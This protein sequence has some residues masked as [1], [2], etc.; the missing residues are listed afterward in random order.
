MHKKIVSLIFIGGLLF[1]PF[2]HPMKDEQKNQETSTW[3][4]TKKCLKE[5][6]VVGLLGGITGSVAGALVNYKYSLGSMQLISRRGM[7]I[8]AGIGALSGAAT[9]INQKY[10]M[11][12]PQ[13]Y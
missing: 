5:A 10:L 2:I 13:F 4:H 6:A 9:Y 8:G 7:L 11:R 3:S 1:T 12:E